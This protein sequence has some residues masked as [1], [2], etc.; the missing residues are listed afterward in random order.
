MTGTFLTERIPP[1]TYQLLAYAFKPLTPEQMKRTGLTPPS[2]EA[3][4]RIEVPL[5]G[6]LAAGELALKPIRSGQ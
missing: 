5:E 1:G 2:F 6:E 4:V 3:Q